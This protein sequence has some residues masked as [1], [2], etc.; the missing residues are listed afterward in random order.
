MSGSRKKFYYTVAQ[1]LHWVAAFI[2][3]FNLLS[4]WQIGTFPLDQKQVLIMIHSGIGTTVF[5]L[6]LFRWRWRKL[7]ELY[8]PPGWQKRPSMLLQW[9]FYPLLLIQPVIGVCLAAFINYKVLAFGFI[10]YSAIAADNEGLHS[11][12]RELHGWVAILLIV[13]VLVHGVDRSRQ[14]FV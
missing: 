11:L 1:T 6:M 14:A 12:F 13:L 4:G 8:T 5:A 2:I 3:A 9:V 7:H 10:N